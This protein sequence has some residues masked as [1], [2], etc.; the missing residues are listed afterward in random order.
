[1]ITDD[2]LHFFPE[3]YDVFS[4]LCNVQQGV[5]QGL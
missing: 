1:M 4:S 2:F 5:G 3:R